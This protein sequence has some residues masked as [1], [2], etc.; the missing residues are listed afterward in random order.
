MNIK[1]LLVNTPYFKPESFKFL[2]SNIYLYN[3]ISYWNLFSMVIL[4]EWSFENDKLEM[5]FIH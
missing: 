4:D 5:L 2:I 3:H 1:F